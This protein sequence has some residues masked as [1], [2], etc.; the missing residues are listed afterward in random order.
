MHKFGWVIF[1][2]AVVSANAVAQEKVDGRWV[3]D[4]LSFAI[5]ADAIKEKGIFTFCV[6]DTA[7]GYCVE[8]LTTGIEVIVFN[9][10]NE[11]LWRGIGSGRVKK[12]KL[13][14]AMPEAHYL[15]I[16]AFKPHV[17]NRST[18]N[19]IHQKKPIEIKYFIK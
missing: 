2:V 12:L 17:V 10:A 7:Q 15:T 1:M 9:R 5:T 19:L 6:L 18:G 3:D 11:E 4:N 13:S 16:R 14:G 8:N